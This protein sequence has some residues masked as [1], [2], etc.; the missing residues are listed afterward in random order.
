MVGKAAD[1]VPDEEENAPL[2]LPNQPQPAVM[3][4]EQHCAP[5]SGAVPVVSD[6]ELK[7]WDAVVNSS[8]GP[9]DENK[10]GEPEGSITTAPDQ[11]PT[12]EGSRTGPG[13]DGSARTTK[14]DDAARV[15]SVS[16]V[17]LHHP[18][19]RMR[20]QVDV[21]VLFLYG[22]TLVVSRTSTAHPENSIEEAD[23]RQHRCLS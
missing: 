18:S 2:D 7:D 5:P 20:T 14:P 3:V 9:N 23:F 4:N 10:N 11:G 6:A 21:R 12:L 22:D 19:C 13:D 16:L 17:A 8:Q 15:R 1:A